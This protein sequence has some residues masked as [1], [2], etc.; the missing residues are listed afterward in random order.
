M[1]TT[2]SFCSRFSFTFLSAHFRRPVLASTSR[3]SVGIH[4]ANGPVACTCNVRLKSYLTRVG[5]PTCF[6][7]SWHNLD[8]G[9]L[10]RFT[11]QAAP[12][13]SISRSMLGWC[14]G[15]K[16]NGFVGIPSYLVNGSQSVINVSLAYLN[17][18]KVICKT[19]KCPSY[20]LKRAS[21]QIYIARELWAFP[22]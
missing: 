15:L 3:L 10:I 19:Q 13:L 5:R 22:R 1:S 16:L 9:C 7:D 4:I 21:Y 2:I 8:H 14:N 12:A 11:V 17:V 20:D 18:Q 6:V